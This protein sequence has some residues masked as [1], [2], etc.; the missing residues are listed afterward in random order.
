M[1]EAAPALPAVAGTGRDFNRRAARSAMSPARLLADNDHGVTRAVAPPA[2]DRR[3]DRRK[4]VDRAISDMR[5]PLGPVL[6]CIGSDLRLNRSAPKNAPKSRLHPYNPLIYSDVPLCRRKRKVIQS[7]RPAIAEWRCP[8][9]EAKFEMFT[10]RASVWLPTPSSIGL[11][12]PHFSRYVL[13]DT[14]GYGARVPA[15]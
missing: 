11:L 14:A 2:R 1:C 9:R 6:W 10:A 15:A 3:R 7:T 13:T 5:Q 12:F 8:G 4:L